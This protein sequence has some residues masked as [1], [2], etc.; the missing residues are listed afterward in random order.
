[1]NWDDRFAGEGY[2]FGTEPARFLKRHAHWLPRGS[3][4]LLV[5]D[6]EGRNSVWLAEMGHRVTA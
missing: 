5:A 3:E 1:M 6:G 2:L 4:V